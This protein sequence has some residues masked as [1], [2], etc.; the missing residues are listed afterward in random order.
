MLK[1]SQS[2]PH[3][4]SPTVENPVTAAEH[5]VVEATAAAIKK[6]IETSDWAVL[7]AIRWPE[8]RD[9]AGVGPRRGVRRK[10]EFS[11]LG[12]CLPEVAHHPDAIRPFV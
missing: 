11:A 2:V 1:C 4:C 12:A 10:P 7:E 9:Q 6:V 8:P 5:E 3:T